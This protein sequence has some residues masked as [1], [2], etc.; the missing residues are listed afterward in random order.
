MLTV[1]I[2]IY[3][4][5][6][7]NGLRAVWSEEEIIR[8]PYCCSFK[9]GTGQMLCCGVIALMLAI[10]QVCCSDS[11]VVLARIDVQKRY[12]RRVGV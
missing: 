10:E 12:E 3:V 9:T 5:R 1:S 11:R 4:R 6:S 8:V 2:G 7:G